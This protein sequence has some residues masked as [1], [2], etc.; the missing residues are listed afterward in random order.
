V[1]IAPEDFTDPLFR[2]AVERI[3]EVVGAGGALDVRS[4]VV[5]GDDELNRL[6]S[7][8]SVLET[9]Y[10]DAGKAGEMEKT[11]S[12]CIDRMKQQGSSKKMKSLLT[13]IQAAESRGDR[14]L[15][16]VL[17]EQ[18]VTIKRSAAQEQQ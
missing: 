8:Y 2:R 17:Q 3:F 7:H 1:R 9:D 10:I 18:L 14:E 15:L 13:A 11:C 4:L 16:R 5:E 12:D 6:F